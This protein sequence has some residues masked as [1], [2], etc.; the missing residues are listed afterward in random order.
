MIA[1]GFKFL[2]IANLINTNAITI[3]IN[4]M[5]ICWNK[6]LLTASVYTDSLVIE[7]TIYLGFSD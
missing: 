2:T 1:I 3:A 6:T 7:H 4:A 5:I